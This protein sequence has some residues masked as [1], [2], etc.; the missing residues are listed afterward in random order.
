VAPAK[1]DL[2]HVGDEVIREEPCLRLTSG[3]VRR[4]GIVLDSPGVPG[5]AS[6][7]TARAQRAQC[8]RID[9]PISAFSMWIVTA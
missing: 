6:G 5:K 7:P 9:R 3:V 8:G 2:S 1:P 4:P